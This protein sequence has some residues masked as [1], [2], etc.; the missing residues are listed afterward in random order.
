[1]FEK[2]PDLKYRRLWLFVGYSLVAYVIYSSLTPSP[3]HV[4]VNFFDKYAHT[5]GYFVLMGWFMQLYHVR[6]NIL[7]CGVLLILMGISIEFIQDLTGYRFFD[8]YDMM[9]N[10]AGVL[11]A[12]SLSKTP[13]PQVLSY[14]ERKL[15][16]FQK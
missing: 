7:Q 11:L 16:S 12:W 3:I 9:A 6:K 8:I 2:N 15:L 14:F 10:T 1:M 4:D 5:F 13:F